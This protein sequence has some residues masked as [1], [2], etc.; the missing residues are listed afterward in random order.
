MIV[1]HMLSDFE[2]CR[3][4]MMDDFDKVKQKWA[5][6]EDWNFCNESLK[7]NEFDAV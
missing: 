4:Y 1:E 3:N 7:I 6:S 5:M 2:K